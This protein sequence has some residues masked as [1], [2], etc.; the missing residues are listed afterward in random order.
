MGAGPDQSIGHLVSTAIAD[1]QTLVRDQVELTKLEVSKSAKEF[2][3]SAG[4][5]IGAGTLGF[6]G[7]I[8]LLVTAAYGLNAA[9]LSLWLS[10]LI[11]AVVVLIVAAILALLGKKRIDKAKIGPARAAKQLEQT[12]AAF[13]APIESLKESVPSLPAKE[14]AAR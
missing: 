3:S 14:S 11:V 12:K 4:L 8:F 6:V 1:V 9:G 13:A 5:L 7:F 10:F 2:G